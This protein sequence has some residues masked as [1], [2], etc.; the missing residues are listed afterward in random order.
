MALNGIIDL[1]S[2]TVRLVVYDIKERLLDKKIA[3]HERNSAFVFYL[4]WLFH[5]KRTNKQA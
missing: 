2:N 3:P 1:G 4:V 5:K